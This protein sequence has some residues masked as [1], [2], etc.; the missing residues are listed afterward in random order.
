MLAE[1]D[2]LLGSCVFEIDQCKDLKKLEEIRV[3]VFGKNGKL[4]EKMK[5]LKNLSQE[6]KRT[7]GAKVNEVKC[8]IIEKLSAKSSDL[9]MIELEKKLASEKMDVSMPVDVQSFP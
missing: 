1:L 6:E 9:E 7:V 3:A 5:C 2:K 8:A 4:T